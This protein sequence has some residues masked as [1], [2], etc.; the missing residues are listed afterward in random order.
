MEI[1]TCKFKTVNRTDFSS[2]FLVPSQEDVRKHFG[3]VEMV[4]D[5]YMDQKELNKQYKSYWTGCALRIQ[6]QIF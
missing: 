1:K 5:D 6:Y 3:D 4:E 2:P